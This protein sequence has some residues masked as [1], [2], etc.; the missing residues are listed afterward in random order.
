[1]SW[2]ADVHRGTALPTMISSRV[3]GW[4]PATSH[5]SHTAVHGP[6]ERFLQPQRMLLSLLMGQMLIICPGGRQAPHFRDAAA[7]S[8]PG[9]Y[10]KKQKKLQAK[11]K[12]EAVT[13][14]IRYGY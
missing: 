1:M 6:Q 5:M 14:G 8:K 10:H 3:S 4:W 2:S 9:N 7:A 13:G 11:E 12:N